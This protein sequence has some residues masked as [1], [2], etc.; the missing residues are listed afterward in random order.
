MKRMHI[1]IGVKDLDEGVKFYSALFNTEPAKLKSDYAKWMLDDPRINFAISTNVLET[2]VNHLGLQVDEEHEMQDIRDRI[3]A[4]GIPTFSEG[5]TT[6]CYAESDKSWVRDPAGVPW[7]A[8]R[9]M[10]DAN[11][12]FDASQ[13]TAEEIDPSSNKPSSGCCVPG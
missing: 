11:V 12:F 7:E 13:T 1:H 2:G 4:A 8:Y 5:E 10:A 3:Q 6:C 9:T